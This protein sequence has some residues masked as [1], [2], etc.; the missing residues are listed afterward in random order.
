M[1]A[2]TGPGKSH[3]EGISLIELADLFPDEQAAREWFEGQRWPDGAHCPHCGSARVSAVA[4]GKPMPWRCRDCRKHFSVRTGTVMAESKLPLRK[5][6]FAVYLCATNLKGA[7]S[8]KLHRDLNITQRSAWFLAHRIREAFEA[9]GGLFACPVEMDETYM[10]GKRK[11]MP[12]AKRETLEGRGAVGKVAVAG[13]K[14]RA[15]KR[16][17]ARVVE[18]T[19]GATPQGFVRARAEAGAKVYT[20]DAR[21][22]RGM[23]G[24]DHEAARHSVGEYVRGMAHTNGMESFWAMLKRGCHG[25]FHH[26][27][28]KHMQRYVNEFAARQGLRER[29]TV[30]MMGAVVARMIGRRLT[31]RRLIGKVAA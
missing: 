23:A 14:D 7:S 11:N 5:W 13:A 31:Y 19:D 6:A 24:F 9:E 28:A 29:D 26:F 22:Y 25:T 30:D 4:S 8:M 3:C 10:G 1:T 16:V 20:D 12:K 2:Q 27:S 21:A 15:T 17:S 18:A